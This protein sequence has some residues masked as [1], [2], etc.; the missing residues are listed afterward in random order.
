MKMYRN[1]VLERMAYIMKT[2]QEEKEDK[3]RPNFAKL[4]REMGCDY[5]TVK[6]AYERNLG[7]GNNKVSRAP[8]PSKLDPYKVLVTEKL[9]GGCTYSSIFLFI[10]KK[11]YD[12]GYTILR[13]YCS[14]MVAEKNRVAQMRYETEPGFQAQVDWKESM[15]LVDRNGEHHVINIFLMVLGF[16]RAKYLELTLDK[17]QDTL[18]S[19]MANAI[20]FFGGSPKEV[21]FD[22]MKTVADHS[23]GDFGQ[24]KINEEFIAFSK[25]A[26]FTPRLCRAFRPQT[27]GKAEALAKLTERLR[28]YSGEFDKLDELREI[29]F[30]LMKDINSEKSEATGKAPSVLLEQEK[31]YLHMPDIG[32]LR[33][34]Y[35]SRP[36]ERKVSR[37]SMVTFCNC[38]YSVEPRYIGK[39]VTLEPK[40]GKLYI[41]LS[42]ELIMVHELSEKRY[43]YSRDHYLAIMRSG[44]FKD[45]PDDLVEKIADENL[46]IYDR[47]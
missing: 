25:D 45:S 7:G 21:L 36:V 24:G 19:C 9:E 15:M 11:G 39:T 10:R 4:A 30:Q 20:E 27:K 12:G 18:F 33:S 42:K 1:D 5:R 46:A 3:I 43:N 22:N 41:Y 40:E 6:A 28:P 35:V 26:L 44:A 17:N 37:E 29:V 38:K 16:S 32:L 14:R 2:T 34:T 23:R 8:R 31:K 47:L 13:D